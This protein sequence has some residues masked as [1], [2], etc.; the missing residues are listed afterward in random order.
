MIIAPTSLTEV[1]FTVLLGL[2]KKL[3]YNIFKQ[4]RF[5]PTRFYLYIRILLKIDATYS[6]KYTKA[7]IN[8]PG[9]NRV[10]SLTANL[11]LICILMNV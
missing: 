2:S 4:T 3:I 6:R 1:I 5:I 11:I 9:N 10:E 8:K 7:S